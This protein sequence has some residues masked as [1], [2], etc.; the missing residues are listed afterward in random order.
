MPTPQQTREPRILLISDRFLPEVGGSI[1][2]F[3]NAYRRYPAGTTWILTKD[4]PGAAT[5]DAE[6]KGVSIV[7][8][9]LR[10]YWFLKPESLLMYMNLFLT[11]LWIGLRH[12]IDII[13]A[14]KVLPEG[15]VARI[16]SK[17]LRI[18]YVVYAHGEEITVFGKNPKLAPQMLKVY[19]AATALI[20]NS[21]FTLESLVRFGCHARNAVKI[22]PGVNPAMFK[23]GPKDAELLHKYDLHEKTVLLS[24]GRHD[25]RKGHD[26]VIRALPQILAACPDIAYVIT[27][28]GDEESAL[29]KLADE[30]EVS[31]SV[32][33]TGEVPFGD[34]PRFYN[35]CD[36][37]I[38]A[39]RML[40]NGDVEGFG[41]VYL[42][43]SACGKPTIAG[44]SGGTGD[45]VRDTWNGRRIDAT[46]PENIAE[47]VIQLAKDPDL[48]TRMGENGRKLVQAEYTWDRVV[49]KT[50]RLDAAL[51]AGQSP[52]QHTAD[53]ALN[54]PKANARN[55]TSPQSIPVGG[56]K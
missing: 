34:L 53:D 41:I 28:T 10:R 52:E 46:R 56:P 47:A 38:L 26:H 45:P 37:F 49:E 11:G 18:P 39:N 4:Y 40:S 1:T 7:R 21:T 32:R 17:V 43:A 15:L 14:S 51:V 27:S 44:E 48:G 8:R 54:A 16:L 50:R 20:A 19:D 9:N 5:L 30:L 12:R 2:W 36:I 6:I 22:S 3:D 25:K 29:K 13:H 24:V 23:P 35:T 33:F 31:A 42:E 55:T